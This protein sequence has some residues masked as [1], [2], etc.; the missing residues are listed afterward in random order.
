[1][2]SVKMR[3]VEQAIQRSEPKVA[4]EAVEAFRAGRISGYRDALDVL[5]EGEANAAQR[6]L[7]NKKIK[8]WVD[9]PAAEIAKLMMLGAYGDPRVP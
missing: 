3:R 2:R 6:E 8:E 9:K 5:P 4:P 1:M 7:L